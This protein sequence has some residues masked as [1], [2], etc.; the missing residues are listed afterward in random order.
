MAIILITGRITALE[1][2]FEGANASGFTYFTIVGCDG[3]QHHYGFRVPAVLPSISPVSCATGLGSNLH[4]PAN[5]TGE[6]D[7]IFLDRRPDRSRFELCRGASGTYTVCITN[8]HGDMICCMYSAT[9]YGWRSVGDALAPTCGVSGYQRRYSFQHGERWFATIRVCLEQW[10]HH[11]FHCRIG[12]RTLYV[13]RHRC[14][15]MFDHAFGRGAAFFLSDRS[16]PG[17]PDRGLYLIGT[18]CTDGQRWFGRLSLPQRYLQRIRRMW[19]PS[20]SRWLIPPVV[21]IW[22]GRCGD[23]SG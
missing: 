8:D 18:V 7:G 13:D 17:Y 6:C 16:A 22:I 21:W 20:T 3:S 4:R 19:I 14:E 1:P 9:R 10:S 11:A 23:R 5:V 2:F 12:S 15:R